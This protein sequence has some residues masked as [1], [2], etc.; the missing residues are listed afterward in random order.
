MQR[1][2][3]GVLMGKGV[4]TL[5]DVHQYNEHYDLVR[6]RIDY[7]RRSIIN[8]YRFPRGKTR[9]RNFWQY[10]WGESVAVDGKAW[11]EAV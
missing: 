8:T 4:W 1:K 11:K 2:E 7:A 10:K 5:I 6:Y 3:W 9:M